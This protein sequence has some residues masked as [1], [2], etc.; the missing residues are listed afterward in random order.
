VQSTAFGTVDTGSTQRMYSLLGGADLSPSGDGTGLR[1]GIYGGYVKSSLD[2]D[3]Y[4]SSAKYEGGVAG[5]YAAYTN[6]GFYADTQVDANFVNLA[7]DAP[8]AG[9]VS[10]DTKG[11]TI[12]VLTNVGNRFYAGNSF[13]EPTA[14][15]AYANTTVSDL[16]SGTANIA[17]QNARSMR[18]A[19]GARVGTLVRGGDGTV[20][21]FALLGRVWDEFGGDSQVTITDG[22][23]SDTF[24][25]NT[26]GIYGELAGSV[27]VSATG[28]GFSSYLS[29]GA[30]FKADATTWNAKIG[31]RQG[32]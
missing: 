22:S 10:G 16:Q 1:L 30:T 2:F 20:A 15:F 17:F 6:E 11:T 7:F 21:E 28:V 25:T 14:A 23:N 8:F 5:A 31:V 27:T 4:G 3:A 19:V 9:G 26:D 32:F 18:A 12:G 13:V 24:T 29:G